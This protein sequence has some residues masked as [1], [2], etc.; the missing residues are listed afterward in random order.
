MIKYIDQNVL[1]KFLEYELGADSEVIDR[2]KTIFF[3]QIEELITIPTS[4][5]DPIA[6]QAHKL[7]ASAHSFGA[8]QLVVLLVDT[9]KAAKNGDI[10][11]VEK[12][13]SDIKAQ[14][15]Q[16]ENEISDIQESLLKIRATS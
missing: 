1:K 7:K 12:L 6:K 13:I 15:Q 11:S 10:S 3:E 8:A 4:Q 16:L 5:L 2:L 14:R 9:E